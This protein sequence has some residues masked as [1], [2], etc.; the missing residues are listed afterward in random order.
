M[1]QEAG[2]VGFDGDT[3]CLREFANIVAEAI[4]GYDGEKVQPPIDMLK[5][6]L[7][8]PEQVIQARKEGDLIVVDLPQVP[9]GSGGIHKEQEPVAYRYWNE[10][11]KCYFFCEHQESD[12]SVYEPIF[13]TPPQREWVGMTNDELLDIA[14]M[15]YANDLELLQTLQAKL[16][17]KNGF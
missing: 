6:K 2:F 7:K 12:G 11:N 9:T 14:D 17:D 1:A 8:Q 4:A 15:A 3:K 13:S 10:H 5:A 16:K